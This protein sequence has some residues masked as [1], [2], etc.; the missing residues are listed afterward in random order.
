VILEHAARGQVELTTLRLRG[1]LAAYVL[2]FLDGGAYRMW[3]CRLAPAWSRYG[4]G[5]I[6]NDAAL[7][8]A[9]ADAGATEFDWM[10]GAE[11]YKLGLSNHVEHA[12]DLRAWS[13]PAL[14]SLLDSRRRFKRLIKNAAVEHEWLQ[15]VLDASQR[16]KF[17]G[18]RGKRAI[19]TALRRARG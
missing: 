4:A 17:A 19:A 15:P 11:P 10:R 13:S 3:N 12:L 14:R 18:R 1:E 7:E 16:L 9:L 5:R 8:R 6:A 2:C